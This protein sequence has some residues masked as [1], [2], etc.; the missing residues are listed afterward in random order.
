MMRNQRISQL[1]HPIPRRVGIPHGKY[2][3]GI[4]ILIGR[5]YGHFHRTRVNP[6]KAP[7]VIAPVSQFLYH[8][9]QLLLRYGR[10]AHKQCNYQYN[11]S[12]RL[13]LFLFLS[14]SVFFLLLGSSL[15]YVLL[16]SNSFSILSPWANISPLPAANVSGNY[17]YPISHSRSDQELPG[18]CKFPL[19]SNQTRLYHF[20]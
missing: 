19:P 14:P 13:A 9:R 3:L 2:A 1:E 5:L 16:M 18:S 10:K 12:H 8:I 6:D 17:P 7:V 20:P 15:L 4:R 11:R